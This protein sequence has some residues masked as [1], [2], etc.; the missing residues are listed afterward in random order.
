MPYLHDDNEAVL[1]GS[2]NDLICASANGNLLVLAH[3]ACSC[4]TALT[5]YARVE[6]LQ[7]QGG[8]SQ[9]GV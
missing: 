1:L 8:F 2:A 7:I 4:K 9:I 5:S 3:L 6:L